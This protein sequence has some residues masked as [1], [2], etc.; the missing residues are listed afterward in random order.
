MRTNCSVS[1]GICTK[2][3]ADS[4]PFAAFVC[5]VHDHLDHAED[6]LM[7]RIIEVIQFRVLTV[8]ERGCTGSGRWFRY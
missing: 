1:V 7:M 8:N 2:F 5:V 6:C 4:C 3:A